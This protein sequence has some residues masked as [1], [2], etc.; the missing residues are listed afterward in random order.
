M[1]SA[2]ALV[3]QLMFRIFTS[4]TYYIALVFF[5]PW[6][7]SRAKSKAREAQEKARD[8]LPKLT[9]TTVEFQKAQCFFVIAVQIAAQIVLS[10][11]QWDASE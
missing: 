5:G 1:Q 10:S 2:I 9:F 8:H 7:A 11:G 4:W 6:G 3:V